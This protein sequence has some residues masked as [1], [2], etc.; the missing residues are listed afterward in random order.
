MIDFDSLGVN[1]VLHDFKDVKDY[2]ESHARIVDGIMRKYGDLDQ[3]FAVLFFDAYFRYIPLKFECEADKQLKVA[4]LGA[5]IKK[6]DIE[7]VVVVNDAW[8]VHGRS[9]DSGM[10]DLSAMPRP[11]DHPDKLDVVFI[12]YEEK[13]VFTM[14]I[15]EKIRD[16]KGVYTHLRHIERAL[17]EPFSNQLENKNIAHFQSN[18]MFFNEPKMETCN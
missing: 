5:L 2:I 10:T 8:L 14:E 15:Y 3:S 16:E 9:D 13:G 1:R 18:F 6:A 11:K 7:K 12:S 17:G 4:L